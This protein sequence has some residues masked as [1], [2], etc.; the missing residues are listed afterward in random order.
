[1]NMKA[2]VVARE[3][4]SEREQNGARIVTVRGRKLNMRAIQSANRMRKGGAQ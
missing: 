2:K 4:I 1:M 3:I